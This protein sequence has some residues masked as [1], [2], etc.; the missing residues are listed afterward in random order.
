VDPA[1]GASGVWDHVSLEI[2]NPILDVAGSSEGD[3][4]CFEGGRI[5]SEALYVTAGESFDVGERIL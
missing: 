5:T 1:V 3:H 2:K 4:N